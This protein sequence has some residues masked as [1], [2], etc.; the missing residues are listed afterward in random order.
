MPDAVLK[1]SSPATVWAR[2]SRAAYKP[3]IHA[4]LQVFL[5][6]MQECFQPGK[7]DVTAGIGKLGRKREPE[8]Q[9]P[10]D[11]GAPP[12]PILAQE[13]RASH[14][15]GRNQPQPTHHQP[16]ELRIGREPEAAKPRA[17]NGGA[18]R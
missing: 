18:R 14:V 16:V 15:P 5:D 12:F 2:R 11:A 4:R 9:R 3:S 7:I 17:D 6:P 1:D 13:T 10:G 8:E